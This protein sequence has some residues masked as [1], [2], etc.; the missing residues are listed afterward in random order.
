MKKLLLILATGLLT[1][2]I[3]GCGKQEEAR[4]ME[5]IYSEE[6]V[7]VRIE[8]V[9]QSGFS[10]EL[11][12]NATLTG[13]KESSAYASF[14]DKI[15]RINCRVGDFVEK[16]EV[17]L[18]FPTDNPAAKYYQAKV[19][20]ENSKTSFER[21]ENLYATG[22]ISRQ[23]LDNAAAAYHVAQADWDAVRQTVKVKAPI[24]GIVTRVNFRES[25]NVQS[26]DE[27]FAIS[28]VDRLKARIWVSDKQIT[29]IEKDQKATARWN[30]TTLAGTVVQVDMSMNHE[31]QAFGVVIEFDNPGMIVRCGVT[32]S[33]SI[34]TYQN[35][36]AVV[37]E[38]KNLIKESDSYYVYTEESGFA[39]KKQ[40]T[41]GK[42]GGLEV[43][44]LRGLNEGEKLITEGQMHLDDGTKI[45]IIETDYGVISE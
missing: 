42:N 2:M 18:S 41:L 29:L 39:R 7:P 19:S 32:A 37:V 36:G 23:A 44:I 1:A 9:N 12:Y 26:E 4:N 43:E 8:T 10:S 24:S 6:G 31:R 17:I 21:I 38:R 16:D 35:S 3:A 25:E 14:G 30:G 20:F 28:Q 13:I 45:K 34:E 15:E 33:I 27:L 40:V 11:E 5:Q 22:G